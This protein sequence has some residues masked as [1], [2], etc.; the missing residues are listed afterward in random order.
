MK[1]IRRGQH[2][3]TLMLL[4]F[5]AVFGFLIYRLQKDA[6]FYMSHARNAPLGLVYDRRGDVLYDPNATADQYGEDHFLDISNL[7]GDDAGQMTNTLVANNKAALTNYSFLLGEQ[8]DGKAAVYTTLD[9]DVNRAVYDAFGK[10]NGCA[11]AYNYVTGEIYV[12]FSKPSIDILDGYEN[13]DTLESGSMLCKVFYPTVPG[14][15]MK[16]LTTVAALEHM[17]YDG[18]MSRSF[19]CSGTYTDLGGDDIRCH[20]RSGHGQQDVVKAF[21]NSCNPFFAQLVEDPGWSLDDIMETYRA[22]GVRINGEGEAQSMDVD[23][24]SAFTASTVLTDKTDFNTQW[25]CMGQGKTLVSPLQMMVWQ[26][27]VANADGR[28]TAPYLIARTTDVSGNE[29]YTAS[30]SRSEAMLTA[31]S[32]A[33]MRE[34]MLTNGRDRYSA[35]LPGTTVGVKSGTAQVDNGASENSLLTGFVDDPAFPV[36]FCIVIE[37]RVGGEVS[38]TDIAGK[39]LQTLKA[40]LA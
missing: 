39:L 10:K 38:N 11:V 30:T 26:S 22:M 27:A 2:L 19:S 13:I 4:L 33:H 32:A 1:S 3:I 37:D 14:S 18:L 9:H 16:V 34:I 40:S 29:S 35:L 20:Q 24:I 7:I 21:E 5:L 23:G 6:G 25:G 36:A 28:T 17:G 31:E 12:C 8:A 15:T